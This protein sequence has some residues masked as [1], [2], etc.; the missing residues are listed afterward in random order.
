MGHGT[1][2]YV[3]V[4]TVV[5]ALSGL[6][7]IKV[8]CGSGD[9]HTLCVTSD[10]KVY[11]WGWGDFGKLGRGGFDACKVPKLI[12]KLQNVEIVDVYCGDQFS[13]ALSKDGKLY[14]WGKGEGGMV[15]HNQE[16]PIR[17]RNRIY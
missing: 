2:E 1:S 9:P 7:V 10:G 13:L 6:Q 3:S 16:E 11:S 14:S 15:G 8:A 17:Y 5:S 12:E 4:P